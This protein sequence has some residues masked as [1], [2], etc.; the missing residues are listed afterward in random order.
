MNKTP[1]KPRK[2]SVT[3]TLGEQSEKFVQKWIS[4]MLKSNPGLI[5]TPTDFVQAALSSRAFEL[6]R[7]YG[8][9]LPKGLPF[10]FA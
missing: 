6:E 5:W 10:P 2:K 3:I 7:I 1:A 4:E 9:T 8:W